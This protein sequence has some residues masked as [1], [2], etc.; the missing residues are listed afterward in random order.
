MIFGGGYYI[1][2]GDTIV[3]WI[4]QGFHLPILTDSPFTIYNR[5]TGQ[6]TCLKEVPMIE[7]INF[8]VLIIA[9]ALFL[10]FYVL[11]VGPEGP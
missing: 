11:S 10:Y 1:A 4:G 2:F 5:L 8:A 9:T 6:F 3:I 7:W